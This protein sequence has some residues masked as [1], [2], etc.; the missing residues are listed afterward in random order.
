MVRRY[1]VRTSDRKV[2]ESG[3]NTHTFQVMTSCTISSNLSLGVPSNGAIPTTLSSSISG[4]HGNHTLEDH[5][6]NNHADVPLKAVVDGFGM[7]I[8]YRW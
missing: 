7:N 8:L 3:R 6:S 1:M 2:F 5:S 4:D